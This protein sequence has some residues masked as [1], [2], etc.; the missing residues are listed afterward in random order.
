MTSVLKL[1]N[2]WDIKS[3]YELQYFNCPSCVYKDHSKQK[4]IVHAYEVHPEALYYLTNILDDSLSDINCPW[5]IGDFKNKEDFKEEPIDYDYIDEHMDMGSLDPMNTIEFCETK[6]KTEEDSNDDTKN[7]KKDHKCET[8]GKAYTSTY[9]LK[10]HINSVHEGLKN[11]NCETCGK[12]FNLKST[13]R[14][15]I[16]NVHEGL[17]NHKCDLCV[18]AFTCKADLKAHIANV[19]EGKNNW[20]Y[21]ER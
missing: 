2:P 3:L 7:V 11:H 8:C 13:L 4:F 20:F 6:M 18:N 9:K 1:E 19:H 12:D 5:N 14:R 16:R 10:R 17:K 21:A 15:H